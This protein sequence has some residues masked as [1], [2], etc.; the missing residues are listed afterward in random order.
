MASR[1]NNPENGTRLSSDV[2]VVGHRGMLGTDLIDCIRAN[3]KSIQVHG[4]DL[5][6]L[7]IA[8]EKAVE[9]LFDELRQRIGTGALK[10]ADMVWAEGMAQWVPASAVAELFGQVPV[11]V[12]FKP[13]RG[14]MILALGIVGLFACFICGI[15]AWVMG[16]NDLKAMAAGVMDPAGAQMTK[17]GKICGM[18]STIIA[19]V[20]FG[21]WLLGVIV[22]IVTAGLRAS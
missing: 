17:A 21:G 16:N 15:L 8:D 19:C 1:N 10:P 20:G 4:G 11:P 13:H 5:P 6:E 22:V 9:R 18:I 14:G 3:S 2:L 7:D 12:P